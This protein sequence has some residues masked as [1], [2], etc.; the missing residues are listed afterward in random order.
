M[1]CYRCADGRAF[2]LLG[3]EADRHWPGLL[4]AIGR[5]ELASE[6]KFLNA[7]TRAVNCEE[8]IAI[9]DTHFATQPYEYWTQQFDA[10]NVWWAPL[11]SIPEA[12]NDEQVIASG[13]FVSMTPQPGEE[14][15]RA[16]N[17]PVDFNGYTPTYGPVPQLGQHEPKW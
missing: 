3:L 7:R 15:Y 16:V 14:P 11:N 8:L 2:W 10:H 6:E 1:N 17:S 12:V 5:Q 9:L 4:E 13:A